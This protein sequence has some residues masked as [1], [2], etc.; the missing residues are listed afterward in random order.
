MSA[1]NPIVRLLLIE[2][3]PDDQW[4]FQDLLSRIGG[5]ETYRVELATT[6]DEALS[7]LARHEHD[8]GI[9]DY[10]LGA[11]TG[12]DLLNATAADPLRPPL[13]LLTG[14]GSAEVDRG[15]LAAGAAD[16]LVKASLDG[17]RLERSLRYVLAQ[18]RLTQRLL[19]RE[20]NFAV[21]FDASPMPLWVYDDETLKILEVNEAAL[22]LY[23]YGREEFLRLKITDL[24][25]EA[26]VPDFIRYLDEH[27]DT[28]DNLQAGIWRHQRKDSSPVHVEIVRSQ[29]HIGGRH[30][31]LVAATD[32]SVRLH[33]ERVLQESETALRQVLHDVSDGLMVTD[34]Q[35]LVRVANPALCV[36]L[37]QPESELIGRPAPKALSDSAESSIELMDGF[38]AVHDIDLRA[39]ESSWKGAAARVLTLRDVTAQRASERQLRLLRRAVESSKDG[40]IIVDLRAPDQPIRYVNAG[41]ERITGYR[42]DDVVGRNC[43]FL[44][45]EDRLQPEIETVG[46][47]IAERQDCEVVLRNYRKDG[48]LFWNRLMLSPVPDESGKVTHYIGVQ[49]DITA[50]KVMEAEHQYLATHDPLT[51]LLRFAGSE[52]RIEALLAQARERKRR[53]VVI[54]VDLDG[55]HSV[56]DTMGFAVGD[57]ALRLVADRLRAASGPECE[58]MR[59]AGEEFVIAIGDVDPAA[60]LT[61]LATR[62]CECIA[63]PMPISQLA[64]LYLTASVGV[65]A[66]PDSGQTV[67][68]LT[69]QADTATKRAKRNGRNGVYV[70]S[71]EL[72]DAL[73]DRLALG[74]RLREALARDEF[75]LY[76]QPQV[77][78]QNGNVVGLEALVRWSSPEFGLLLPNRFIPVAEDNGMILHLGAWVLRTACRQLRAWIDSGLSGFQ[79]SV[80]VSAA[81][82]Q[83]PNFVADV[84]RIL[85][86]TGIDPGM[87]QLEL[88]ESVL[89]DNAERSAIQMRQLNKLGVRI[90]LDDF[91][92]GYSSLSYLRRFP[93]HKLKI[94]QSFIANI[95]QDGK[96]AA[97]VRAMISIGHHLG[98]R[99]VAEGVETAAQSS[100]LLRNHCDEL[101]GF[102]FSEAL[103]ASKIPELLRHRYQTRDEKVHQEPRRTLL[104]LD[105]DEN[106]LRSLI[107]LFRR[108]NYQVLS[109]SNATRAFELLATHSVQVVMSDQRMP[110][111]SGTEFLSQVKALYPETMRIVLSGYTDLAS[112]TDA[113]NRGAI[114]KFLTKPW[115][116]DALC[117]QVQEAFRQFEQ[118]ADAKP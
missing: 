50:Q 42:S 3:D 81:Q 64:T 6:Y 10:L 115:D 9:V 73:S 29:I 84:G 18:H 72:S 33:A 107:R 105:D 44:Q 53:M 17:G 83:R 7:A 14:H 60:D 23:G 110:G 90:A 95:T 35:N 78:A 25:A 58:V 92:V 5:G 26:D 113:I 22:A 111:I 19:E 11:D 66:F 34:M 114:Y 71:N 103:P 28:T 87:L 99:V 24:R 15:A 51:R 102:H 98:M 74:G 100:Y 88:T 49:T 21:I 117:D 97:L 80:N 54:S 30:Q 106:I 77:D 67:L 16:F 101:Q 32:V 93:I 20:R 8:I 59:Y 96:G 85:S 37:G 75:L 70:F 89:M 52:A 82:M 112:V 45:G 31:R 65:S 62:Y 38:G 39:A 79:V 116:D 104:L 27:R 43:R 48:S 69:R 76:Y 56:N 108:E 4:L 46:R 41:F 109:A 118:N 40:I 68:D 61:Q 94:D 1:E 2:D 12:I 91:G 55:F 57:A 63:E 47:A 36:L 86:E 13:I